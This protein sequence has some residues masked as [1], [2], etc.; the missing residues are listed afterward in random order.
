MLLVRLSGT[1]LGSDDRNH[2]GKGIGKVVHGIQDDGNRIGKESHERLESDQKQIGDNPYDAGLYY[3]LFPI[4]CQNCN[5]L[6]VFSHMLP[7][8]HI[9]A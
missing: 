5:I 2:R 9:I 8:V 3:R 1:E 7:R 4:T 6:L